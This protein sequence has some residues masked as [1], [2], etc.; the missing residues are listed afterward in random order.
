MADIASLDPRGNAVMRRLA[1][2]FCLPL[3]FAWGGTAAASTAPAPAATTIETALSAGGG[4][5]TPPIVPGPWQTL[6]TDQVYAFG[7]GD[8][9]DVAAKQAVLLDATTGQVLYAKNPYQESAPSS[10]TKMMTLLLTF[11]R[12]ASGQLKLTSL[13]PVSA[14][15][16]RMGGSKM[17]VRVGDEV[18]VND[19]IQG[20]IVD[21]GN[22]ACIVLAQGIAGTEAAFVALMNGE[23]K[24]LGM[25]HT[26]FV[27]ASG[28]PEP[29]HYS[30]VADLAVLADHL[31]YDF[32]QYYRYFAQLTYTYDGI[33]QGN[34][35]PL[36]YAKYASLNV[37]GLKTGNTE[38]GGYS[39]AVSGE[40]HGVRLIAVLNGA[41]S[42]NARAREGARLLQW[43]FT[44]FQ[45]K[46]YFAAGAE[47]TDA[48]VWLGRKATVPLVT[49]QNVVMT[50]PRAVASQVK[51]TA[52]YNSPVPAPITA[53]QRL[54]TLVLT[55][56][57]AP[58]TAVPLY[59]GAAVARLN[60]FGRIEA[61]L[62]YLIWGAPTK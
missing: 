47:V 8:A 40:K 7:G 4:T 35:N 41:D 26:H 52:V 13:L 62:R 18:S 15:A 9:V 53:G 2:W 55:Y 51:V 56:P 20:V 28:W 33:R 34:R 31:I 30:S 61:A 43:G 3:L 27:D 46:Q 11:K 6:G 36:L 29:D 32:P 58:A 54:A 50:V 42:A 37:D 60:G 44:A 23:A 14:K 48:Q 24:K 57:G 1:L 22:D 16:W 59:A 25:D 39:L 10:L 38:E 17:F 49:H 45:S 5:K 12:L 19:L 21:S